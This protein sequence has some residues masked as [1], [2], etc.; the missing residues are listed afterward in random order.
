MAITNSD[1]SIVLTTKV[2]TS[3]V[4]Q[5]M[6]EATKFARL[7]I[8]EQRRLAQSLSGIYR[9][10]GLD[11]SAAQKKAWKDLKDGTVAAED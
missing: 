8:N 6:N 5:G 2:D 10:Q 9:K 3:G 4:K 11:Q 1:G 7:S